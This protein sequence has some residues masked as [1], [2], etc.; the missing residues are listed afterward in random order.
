MGPQEIPELSRAWQTDCPAPWTHWNF[1]GRA[2]R[3]A[4]VTPEKMQRLNP[5]WD[6]AQN[7][8]CGLRNDET[9]PGRPGE[10]KIAVHRFFCV[11][12]FVFPSIVTRIL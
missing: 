9:G 6:P 4:T 8:F 10:R 3:P 2:D 12:S 11:N 1:P 5:L 7:P